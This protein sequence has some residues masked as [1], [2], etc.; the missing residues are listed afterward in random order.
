[1]CLNDLCPSVFPLGSSNS[2]LSFKV[3]FAI[4]ILWMRYFLGLSS[5]SLRRVILTAFSYG[6]S[7]S[8]LSLSSSHSPSSFKRY[9][10]AF[11]VVVCFLF[12]GISSS[13]LIDFKTL[14]LLEAV[15]SV[16]FYSS[17]SSSSESEASSRSLSHSSPSSSSSSGFLFWTI[18]T[19]FSLQF[20]LTLRV[21]WYSISASI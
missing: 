21:F 18:S 10:V 19:T 1:M 13:S 14:A 5:F 2:P 15:I 16:S 6:W 12:M 4:L 8:S 3:A 20:A 7:S 9:W 17:S 11:F